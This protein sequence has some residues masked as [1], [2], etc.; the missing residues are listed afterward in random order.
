M[1]LVEVERGKDTF[2]V[3]MDFSDVMADRG[4]IETTLGYKSGE[5]PVH[6]S[7]MIDETLL[8]LPIRCEI[9]GGYRLLDISLPGGRSDGVIIGSRLFRTGPIV[10]TQLGKA[11]KGA[12]FVCTLGPLMEIWARRL[13]KSNDP[14]LGYIADVA[15]S[16]TVEAA[17]D[18]LQAHIAEQMH[19]RGLKITNRYSPGYC[20]WSVS[21]QHLLFS[22]LPDGFC[23]VTL[24]ESALMSPIKSV[25]GVIGV[26]RE[27]R[28]RKYICD[29]CGVK[30][31]TYRAMR[32]PRSAKKAA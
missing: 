20:K 13:L 27:V 6:F 24:S 10:M 9:K 1:S 28:R 15:A 17:T 21:E 2:E 18:R 26:G 7:G 31:C 19:S 12:L 29:R 22:L 32:A 8:Q 30:D 11:S 14:A 5:I 25:S 16:V 4:E 23:G 3:T